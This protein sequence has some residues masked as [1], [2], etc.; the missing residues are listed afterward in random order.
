MGSIPWKKGLVVPF[1]SDTSTRSKLDYWVA[2]ERSVP[3][4]MH[5]LPIFDEHN[6]V[7]DFRCAVASVAV[8]RL[9]DDCSG[10]AVGRRLSV[11][12]SSQEDARDVLRAYLA[13]ATSGL[14]GCFASV[15]HSGDRLQHRLMVSP[16]CIIEA[17]LRDVSATAEARAAFH[18]LK[19]NP[20]VVDYPAGRY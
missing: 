19:S 18:K 3:G 6:A 14:P 13:A 16:R 11:L 7:V 4:R 2:I 1:R 17:E 12:L 15:S 9:L 5:L 10:E 20:E 8:A